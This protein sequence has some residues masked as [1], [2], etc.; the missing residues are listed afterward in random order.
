MKK[1]NNQE[2]KLSLKK[3][4]IMKINNMKAIFGGGG[5]LEMNFNTGGDE[6]PTIIPQKP[7]TIVKP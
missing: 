3:T 1:T 4:Q 2:K 7:E 5:G 6:P